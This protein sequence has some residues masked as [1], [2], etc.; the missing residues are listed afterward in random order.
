MTYR[1]VVKKHDGNV[2]RVIAEGKSER[3]AERI[4]MGVLTNLDTDRFF[5]EVEEEDE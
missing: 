1:V 3:A 2:E 5:V 4:E